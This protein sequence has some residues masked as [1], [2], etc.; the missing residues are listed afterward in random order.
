MTKRR[1]GRSQNVPDLLRA[2]RGDQNQFLSEGKATVTE[3]IFLVSHD[4]AC[5]RA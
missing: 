5:V 4:R 1:K 2:N 3:D